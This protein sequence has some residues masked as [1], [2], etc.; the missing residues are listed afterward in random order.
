[1]LPFLPISLPK[2][3][4]ADVQELITQGNSLLHAAGL[5]GARFKLDRP[6]S[7]PHPFQDAEVTLI[8]PE[9]S[10]Q[11]VVQKEAA[12][13]AAQHGAKVSGTILQCEPAGENAI[14]VRA[15]STASMFIGSIPFHLSCVVL[16]IAPDKVGFGEIKLD[17]G[18]GMFGGMA[19][20]MIEPH[21]QK[22]AVSEPSLGAWMGRP[23]HWIRLESRAGEIHCSL[24]FGA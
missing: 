7:T 14:R 12:R 6:A 17:T 18:S 5:E 23:V 8:V 21:L 10:L 13:Q 19:R 4:P 16:A 11:D 9:K 24:R 2:Q 22:W 1:M 15:A 3:A 20:A